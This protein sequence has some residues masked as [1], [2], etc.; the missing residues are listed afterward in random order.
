M[1]QVGKPPQLDLPMDLSSAEPA[2]AWCIYMSTG[3]VAIYFGL[4]GFQVTRVGVWDDIGVWRI[5]V[6]RS[7]VGI[8]GC[9]DVRL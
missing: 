6:Y 9:G 3:W 2:A 7:F 8:S 5:L 1:G 4:L